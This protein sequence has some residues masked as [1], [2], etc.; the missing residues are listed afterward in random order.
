MSR[1]VDLTFEELLG[2]VLVAAGKAANIN[3]EAL[4]YDDHLVEAHGFDSL[5]FVEI[6]LFLEDSLG[7]IGYFYAEPSGEEEYTGLSTI[8]KISEYLWKNENAKTNERVLPVTIPSNFKQ[9]SSASE[10]VMREYCKPLAESIIGEDFLQIDKV[11][12]CG[13]DFIHTTC[14]FHRSH[15]ILDAHFKFGPKIVPGSLIQESVCQSALEFALRLFNTSSP[16][17][18]IT[19]V[20]SE[21]LLPVEGDCELFNKVELV[22]KKGRIACF[23]AITY[24]AGRTVARF[25]LK[26]MEKKQ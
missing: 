8:R 10:K 9:Q 3:R 1:S 2:I 22:E 11:I 5:A 14:F 24:V 17:Y 23:S 19:G 7:S 18:F 12:D 15:P 21:F 6:F 25:T 13:N 4:E 16:I 26:A 20:Q